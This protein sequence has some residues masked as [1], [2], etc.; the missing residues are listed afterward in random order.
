MQPTQ[1]TRT[2][3]VLSS[4]R[5]RAAV[6]A[7]QPDD[8]DRKKLERSIHLATFEIPLLRVIGSVF[9]ATGV[10]LNDRFF[11]DQP[12]ILPWT[13]VAIV[14]GAYCI[15]STII[16]RLFYERVRPVDLH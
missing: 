5:R 12:Q 11:L 1:T 3:R 15:V 16:L 6:V 2:A 13:T 10:F 9:L 8:V 14:L 4:A 7:I